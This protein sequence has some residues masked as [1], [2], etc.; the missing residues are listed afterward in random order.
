[1]THGQSL[2]IKRFPGTIVKV[3]NRW[4]NEVFTIKGYR[5]DWRGTITMVKTC[6]QVLIIIN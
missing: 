3:F 5:N 1:M 6:L 4:G 2:N